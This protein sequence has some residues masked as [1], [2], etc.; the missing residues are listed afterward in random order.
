MDKIEEEIAGRIK[1]MM[2]KR[3]VNQSELARELGVHQ[4]DISR[5]LNGKPFPSISQLTMIA[6]Y[7]DCSLYYLIGIQEESY[8]ELS[9]ETRKIADAYQSANETIKA[10]VDLVLTNKQITK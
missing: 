2:D 5:M 1:E 4:Y 3:K 9:P 10:V 8:R 6:N 7:L